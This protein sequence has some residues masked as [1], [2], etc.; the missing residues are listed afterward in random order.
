MAQ[1]RRPGGG[2]EARTDAELVVLSARGDDEA[3][4]ELYRRHA[5]GAR[6]AAR[7]VT[8][9]AEDVDDAVAEAF[10]RVY[11]ILRRGS[12]PEGAAF[13]PYLLTSTR[14]AA[15]DVLR[16]APR[17]VPGADLDSSSTPATTTR[18]SEQVV[19]V[20]NAEMVRRAHLGLPSHLRTVLELTE[21]DQLP[22]REVAERLGLSPNAAAQRA[23]RA[24]A[25]LRQRY[26][27]AHLAPSA[28]PKCR[29]TVERLGA[30][31]GGGLSARDTAK[32][33]LHLATCE[34]CRFRRAE[35]EDLGSTLR[36]TVLPNPPLARRS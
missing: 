4:A 29:D 14:H 28:E 26:L 16:R 27:Q 2:A 36:R 32:V 33:D 10:A 7:G 22:M 13:R 1:T 8:P 9:N 21:V 5:D 20:E 3:F 31:V 15:I 35:L 19:A 17:S 12:F 30:Y 25:R 18:P 23:V 6:W 34:A 11:R 24:R